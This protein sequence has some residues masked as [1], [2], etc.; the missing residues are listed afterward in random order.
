[1]MTGKLNKRVE[2]LFRNATNKNA[3]GEHS[4]DHETKTLRWASIEPLSSRELV[5]ALGQESRIS[6]RIRMRYDEVTS[7]LLSDDRIKHED[8]IYL[9]EGD[10]VNTYQKNYELV[11]MCSVYDR[12]S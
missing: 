7:G 4:E 11:F 5:T 8:T 12:Q 3:Y 1:M 6:V 9:I 2:L 10:P